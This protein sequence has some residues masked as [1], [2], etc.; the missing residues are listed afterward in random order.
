M[1]QSYLDNYQAETGETAILWQ[2]SKMIQEKQFP[3][4]T[5]NS[6][7][8]LAAKLGWFGFSHGNQ[9]ITIPRFK[10]KFMLENK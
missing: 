4:S 6:L 2:L 8:M 3:L 5:P 1:T 9:E 7:I 10:T